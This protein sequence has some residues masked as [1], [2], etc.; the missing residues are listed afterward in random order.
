MNISEL[1]KMIEHLVKSGLIPNPITFSAQIIATIIL[2]LVLKRFVWQP[3][4]EYLEKRQDLIVDE[5][6][7]ATAAKNE[8]ENMKQEYA[9]DLKNAK[10]E[11]NKIIE[12]SR[13]QAKEEKDKILSSAEK[14]A[15]YKIKKAEQEIE[16]N[17]AKVEAELKSQVVDIALMAAEKIVN[18]NIDNNQN[19]ELIDKFIDEV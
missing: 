2:F 9:A 18:K 5:L 17:K 11:A 4:N 8:A 3:I 12:N 14:E 13:M 7:S 6:E 10:D 15:A 1:G 16:T 19:R